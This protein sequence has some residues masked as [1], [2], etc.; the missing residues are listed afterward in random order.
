M[1]KTLKTF[2]YLAALDLIV[3]SGIGVGSLHYQHTQAAEQTLALRQQEAR[4]LMA[5]DMTDDATT[6]QPRS[7]S[8][9]ACARGVRDDYSDDPV[10]AY[11]WVRTLCH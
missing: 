6:N 2:L 3:F 8:Y 4:R 10:K 5:Q 1:P 9:E 7:A 11:L